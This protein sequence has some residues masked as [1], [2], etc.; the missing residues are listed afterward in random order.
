MQN[1]ASAD[2][3]LNVKNP[4]QKELRYKQREFLACV[5]IYSSDSYRHLLSF[6]AMLKPYWLVCF[7]SYV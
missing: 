6:N 4:V 5:Q 1:Y 2:P 3:T 7:F